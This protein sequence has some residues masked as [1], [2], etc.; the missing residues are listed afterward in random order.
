MS[1]KWVRIDWGNLPQMEL[2]G[3]Y[4]I[5]EPNLI[6]PDFP[7]Y[8]KEKRKSYRQLP[9]EDE[10]YEVFLTKIHPTICDNAC[11]VLPAL[12]SFCISSNGRINLGR[13]QND[14][15]ITRKIVQANITEN[16]V[17]VCSTY[18]ECIAAIWMLLTRKPDDSN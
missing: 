5:D 1:E 4:G 11:A 12:S 10:F 17:Q 9:G 6:I 3:E 15:R 18:L 14:G 8:I 16:T 13:L 7:Q 2:V